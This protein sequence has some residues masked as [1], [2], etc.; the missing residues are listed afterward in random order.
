MAPAFMIRPK[1]VTQA[2]TFMAIRMLSVLDF[3]LIDLKF[4]NEEPNINKYL[5]INNKYIMIFE[6]LA[7]AGGN[8]SISG[9]KA[10]CELFRHS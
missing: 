5:L 2:N 8:Q 1:K 10:Q 9:I 3:M 6:K 4:L 7:M